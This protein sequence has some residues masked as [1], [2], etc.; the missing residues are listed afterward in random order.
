M[1]T[2]PNDTSNPTSPQSDSRI[3]RSSR[4]GLYTDNRLEVKTVN[5]TSDYDLFFKLLFNLY[6]ELPNQYGGDSISD[7]ESTTYISTGHYQ[8][9][10]NNSPSTITASFI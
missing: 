10:N 4:Y 6:L 9:I 3:Y 8:A 1:F 2:A 7:I 5:Y